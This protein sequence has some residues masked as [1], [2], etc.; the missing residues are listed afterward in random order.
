M[1]RQLVSFP[2]A[3]T[4]AFGSVR[5]LLGAK[6]LLDLDLEMGFISADIR[7]M[8]NEVINRKLIFAVASACMAGSLFGFDTGNI[9]SVFIQHA[10][11]PGTASLTVT[12]ASLF[13]R[14]SK[15]HSV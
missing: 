12:A 2:S 5:Y 1:L 13:S 4:R 11:L 9:G 3:L 15:R 6:V 8:P 7:A 14:P 10:L